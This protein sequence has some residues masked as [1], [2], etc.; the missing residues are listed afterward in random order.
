MQI[1]KFRTALLVF[2]ITAL[3]FSCKAKQDPI[4]YN[5][6]LITIMGSSDAEMSSMNTAMMTSN[7]TQ[8]KEIAKTWKVK[9]DKSMK[10]IEALGD[11]NGD[12]SYKNEVIGALKTYSDVIENE[13][14]NLIKEREGLKAGTITTQDNETKILNEINTKLEKAGNSIN[15]ASTAFEN[16]IKK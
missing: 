14:P 8:A 9:L 10:D 7:F 2:V 4:E 3:F 5:N 12:P 1:K 6:K 16:K 15:A 13:Y 11:F